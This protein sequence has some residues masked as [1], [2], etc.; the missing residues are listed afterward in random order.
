MSAVLIGVGFLAGLVVGLAG[1]VFNTP[2]DPELR[3]EFELRQAWDALDGAYDENPD[4]LVWRFYPRVIDRA[5]KR[6]P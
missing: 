1:A 5:E 6:Q 4:L 3:L 2:D